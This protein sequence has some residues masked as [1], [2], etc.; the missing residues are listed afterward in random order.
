MIPMGW[1]RVASGTEHQRQRQGGHSLTFGR[2]GAPMSGKRPPKK[3]TWGPEAA[4]T[5]DVRGAKGVKWDALLELPG[6]P[7]QRRLRR[8]LVL[9]GAWTA[10]NHR[11]TLAAPATARCSPTPIPDFPT[12]VSHHQMDWPDRLVYAAPQGKQACNADEPLDF[13]SLAAAAGESFLIVAS[14]R[15]SLSLFPCFLVDAAYAAL[16]RAAPPPPAL[17]RGGREEG[18]GR[19]GRAA[20]CAVAGIVSR[21]AA[22]EAF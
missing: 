16:C 17:M 1:L 3:R 11:Q 5:T 21:Q 10:I 18:G 12:V 14:P 6:G 7:S 20:R 2:V 15:H 4:A 19:T 22:K 9:I 13:I 8:G